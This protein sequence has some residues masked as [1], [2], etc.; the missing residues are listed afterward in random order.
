MFTPEETKANA[1]RFFDYF[2]E[3]NLEGLDKEVIGEEYIQ[4]SPGVPSS[5]QSIFQFIGQTIAS[6]KVGRFEIVDMIAVG[7]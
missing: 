1:M 7:D 4:H 5:R 6:F 2:N 3:G